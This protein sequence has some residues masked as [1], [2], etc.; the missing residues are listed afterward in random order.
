MIAIGKTVSVGD[1]VVHGELLYTVVG[2]R[3]NWFSLIPGSLFLESKATIVALF[4]CLT[5]V[6][7]HPKRDEILA[8]HYADIGYDP[9]HDISVF[10]EQPKCF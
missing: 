5:P 3:D 4:D 9:N 8:R 2:F 7:R 10:G 1:V 6:G